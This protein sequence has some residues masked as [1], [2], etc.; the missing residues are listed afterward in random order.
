LVTSGAPQGS[1]LELVL[2]NIFINIL[3]AGVECTISKSADDIKLGG[4]VDSLEGHEALQRDLDRLEHCAV[5]RMKFNK[6]KCQIL[7]LGWSNAGHKYKL[8]D[9]WLES[10][11]AESHLGDDHCMS[12]PTEIVY[13]IPFFSVLFYSILFYSILFYSILFYSI[14]SYSE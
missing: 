9:K 5:N 14:L 7:Y 3:D 11:P 2:F 4:A 12:L 13:S 10:S 1:I 8:G 6:S